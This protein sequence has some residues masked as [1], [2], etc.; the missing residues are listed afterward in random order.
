VA[1]SPRTA[2]SAA[3]AYYEAFQ[4]GSPPISYAPSQRDFRSLGA[5][6]RLA[7]AMGRSTELAAVAGY[8]YFLF[9]PDRNLDFQAPSAG[10]EL[11]WSRESSDGDAEWEGLAGVGYERRAFAGAVFVNP[12]QPPL[13]LGQGCQLAYGDDLRVDQPLTA[14]VEL[15]R[16]GRVLVGAGYALQYIS[17][18]SF[19]FTML[20]QFVTARFAAALPWDLLFTARAELLFA[21]YRDPLL[22]QGS[23]LNSVTATIEDES[24]SSVRAD[25]SWPLSERLQLIARYTYYGR[26]LS[27]SAVSYSRQTAML[28]VAFT[29]EK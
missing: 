29:I 28:A 18:N 12:C 27:D 9:K 10:L 24:H 6:L 23:I 22:L 5:T 13:V 26:A 8:R 21:H 1:L 2:L 16:T 20:R 7:W 19:E 4:R 11:R 14:R 25:L 15:A 3:G 17:S